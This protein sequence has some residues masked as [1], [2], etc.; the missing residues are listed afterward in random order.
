MISGHSVPFAAGTLRGRLV[1]GHPELRLGRA[2]R[3]AE[4]AGERFHRRDL[5]SGVHQS[6]RAPRAG[7]DRGGVQ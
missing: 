7:Q 2:V 6:R 3:L 5:C 1:Q 4:G